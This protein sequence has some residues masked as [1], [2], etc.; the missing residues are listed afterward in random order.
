MKHSSKSEK[1][2]KTHSGYGESLAREKDTL[3]SKTDR[4][5][6]EQLKIKEFRHLLWSGV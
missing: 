5:P 1:G 6:D 2:R 3:K 4:L